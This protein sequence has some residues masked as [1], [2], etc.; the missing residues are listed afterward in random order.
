MPRKTPSLLSPR[1]ERSKGTTRS[2]PQSIK[3]PKKTPRKGIPFTRSAVFSRGITGSDS[4]IGDPR[5]QY[6]F[7]GRSN[8]G[9]S[10]S[11]N[12]L[13]GTPGL[14]RASATPGKTIA[15]NFFLVDDRY[16]VVDLP[17]YGYARVGGRDAEKMRQHIL[18]YLAGKETHPHKVVL[19][20]D[21]AVGITDF[22]RDLVSICM[23]KGH[24]L[25]VLMNKWDKLNQKERVEAMRCI[26]ADLP[27]GIPV[28][29]F[30][31]ERKIGLDE[32]R[33]VI[34]GR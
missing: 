3:L 24:T 19:I 32:A 22:D 1:T 23:T 30:S 6:A 5:P 9:K 14:A 17:G 31:A 10:S 27:E 21:S 13:L 26:H 15:I 8:T 4:I 12:A 25:V 18:W 11:I 16:Y 33:R 2:L 34:F 20:L 7:V 29:A 28:I